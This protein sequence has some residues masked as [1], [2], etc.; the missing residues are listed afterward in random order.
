MRRARET[1]GLSLQDLVESTR[2]PEGLLEAFETNALFGH[3]AFNRV[4]LRSVVR[5][6]AAAV[7]IPESEALDGLEQALQG[8]YHGE[9][10]RQH[11]ASSQ[12]PPTIPDDRD[13]APERLVE[14]SGK[15]KQVRR[16][17]APR[18]TKSAPAR[19]TV[20]ISSAPSKDELASISA[21]AS[22]RSV[23]VR[24]SLVRRVVLAV[25]AIGSIAAAVWFARSVS[26][27]GD[28]A[29]SSSG[30]ENASTVGAH[31]PASQDAIPD[32]E[33]SQT[34]FSGGRVDDEGVADDLPALGDS[35]R[36]HVRSLGRPVRDIRIR[37]DADLRRPFWIERDST[38]AIKFADRVIIEEHGGLVVV[39]VPSVN[40]TSGLLKPGSAF[41]LSRR[42]LDRFLNSKDLREGGQL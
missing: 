9:L 21:T 36:V 28:A 3:P 7:R 26:S 30:I 5:G 24:P 14:T 32:P 2:I 18:D 22:A 4:Y 1:C 13:E 33:S 41:V 11:A 25:V 39:E 12:K 42:R 20:S 40:Y 34:V 6:Y 38:L 15:K 31:V 16:I 29:D 27:R 8:R 19:P 10:A 35:I 23:V 17:P 37:V